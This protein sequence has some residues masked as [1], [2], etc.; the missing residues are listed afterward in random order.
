MNKYKE[1]KA[2]IHIRFRVIFKEAG[3]ALKGWQVQAA[4]L[5]KYGKRYSESTVTA[6][7][8]EMKDI[9]CNLS[10]YTYSLC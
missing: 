10:D 9:K 7:I 6:R 1:G 5:L 4:Y 2:E 8:R 3:K